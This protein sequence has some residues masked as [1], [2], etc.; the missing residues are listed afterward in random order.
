MTNWIETACRTH[1]MRLTGQRKV[2]AEVVAQATDHPDV[3]ELHRRVVARSPK[4]SL[5]TVYRT[6]KRFQDAG[7]LDRHS[8]QDH[9]ARYEPASK[10]HHDHLIDVESGEVIEF[11]SKS[12]ERLQAKIA[13]D[14]GFEL[15][16]HR[17]E[18]YAR[19]LKP[20]A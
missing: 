19:R 9:R 7:I 1:G 20:R 18:L 5:A 17:L 10:T 16:G 11:S 2:I 3:S 13:R 15:V 14:L 8:F 4:V 12:V 6:V